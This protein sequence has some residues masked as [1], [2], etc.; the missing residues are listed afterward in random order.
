M[1]SKTVAAKSAKKV[2]AP[3]PAKVAKPAKK[4]KNVV[5]VK[6]PTEATFVSLKVRAVIPTQQYGNIQPEIEV[7]APTY[8]MAR[9]F[10]MPRIEELYK[11]YAERPVNGNLP[12]FVG[13]IKVEEKIV[14]APAP[15]APAASPVSS[16]PAP[17]AAPASSGP[18]SEA[19]LKAEKMISL[20]TT[21]EAALL[22]QDKIEKSVKI[23]DEE[24]P[25]LMTL[26]LNK[27]NELK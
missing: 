26:V 23:T 16:A 15:K 24:K 1:P 18:K 21:P 20:A 12:S 3:K 25:A 19:V 7:I 22:I 17:E 9:D 14:S 27:R 4:E 2:A 6:A 10:V 13:P 11:T 8:E 5:N